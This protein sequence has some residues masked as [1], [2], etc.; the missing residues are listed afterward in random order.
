MYFTQCGS[1]PDGEESIPNG[2]L[3]AHTCTCT[4][5]VLL[6]IVKAG[7]HV[8]VHVHVHVD[9]S[10]GEVLY[11]YMRKGLGIFLENHEKPAATRD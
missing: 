5:R 6:R 3:T 11:M 8:H 7:C 9:C 4:D 10:E 2:V 1:S